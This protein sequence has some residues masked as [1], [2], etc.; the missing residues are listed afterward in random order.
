MPLITEF[1]V[2]R[3]IREDLWDKVGTIGPNSRPN[4][5][6]KTLMMMTGIE[7]VDEGKKVQEKRRVTSTRAQTLP[8]CGDDGR[9]MV[10]ARIMT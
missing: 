5:R 7:N 6:R 9:G 1:N 8:D 4:L 3:R 2:I 10:C